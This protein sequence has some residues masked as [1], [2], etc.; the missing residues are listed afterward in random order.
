MQQLHQ[1]LEYTQLKLRKHKSTESTLQNISYAI[2][3]CDA[4]VVC[5]V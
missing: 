5:S 3:I 1:D 2:Y 4:N